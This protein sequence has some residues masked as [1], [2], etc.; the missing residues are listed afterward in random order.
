MKLDR[1]PLVDKSDNLNL[2]FIFSKFINKNGALRKNL[3]DE[4]DAKL[5][6]INLNRQLDLSLYNK[7]I[8]IFIE[9]GLSDIDCDK[10]N[11][12]NYNRYALLY[13]YLFSH[14]F[15][16]DVFE[17]Q[18]DGDKASWVCLS[19][20]NASRNTEKYLCIFKEKNGRFNTV[21]SANKYMKH[22]S[23]CNIYDKL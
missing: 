1:L 6:E 10:L 4:L 17:L 16:C 2:F 21:C 23:Q 18:V 5:K 11:E 12:L 19:R 14:N 9:N 8:G 15:H 22:P 20:L 7:V 3:K 13:I